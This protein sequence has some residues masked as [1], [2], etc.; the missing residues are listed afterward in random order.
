MWKTRERGPAEV[1][2]SK[3]NVATL[4]KLVRISGL[5]DVWEVPYTPSFNHLRRYGRFPDAN[6]GKDQGGIHHGYHKL[7]P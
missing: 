3:R 5:A 6:N 4:P 1:V 2:A 7:R